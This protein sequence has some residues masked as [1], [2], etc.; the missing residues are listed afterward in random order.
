[1]K[2]VTIGE[3]LLETARGTEKERVMS[4][5]VAHE[6]RHQLSERVSPKIEEIRSEQ[7]RAFEDS[8]AVVLF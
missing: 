4:E 2:T 6:A 7:R 8:K 5:E 1:M 3:F